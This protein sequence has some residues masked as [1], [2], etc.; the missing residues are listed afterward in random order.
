MFSEHCGSLGDRLYSKIIAA[1]KRFFCIGTSSYLTSFSPVKNV[2]AGIPDL[3]AAVVKMS[4]EEIRVRVVRME[5]VAK[6]LGV[7][8]SPNTKWVEKPRY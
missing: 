6:S 5:K 3:G 8:L 2:G 1:L 4:V 7:K